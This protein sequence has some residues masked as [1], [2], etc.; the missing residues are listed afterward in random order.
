MVYLVVVDVVDVDL[1]VQQLDA[2]VFVLLLPVDD[3]VVVDFVIDDVGNPF[4]PIDVPFSLVDPSPMRCGCRF[5]CVKFGSR[6]KSRL[7][8]FR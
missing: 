2:D 8:C 3:I 1:L 6:P 5:C 4:F 7:R